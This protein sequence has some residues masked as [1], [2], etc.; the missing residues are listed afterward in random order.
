MADTSRL[1]KALWINIT[2]L[3]LLPKS[4]APVRF[5]LEK[6]PFDDEEE[7]QIAVDRDEYVVTGR[8]FPNADIYKEGAFR[9]EM[10]LTSKYPIEPPVVRFLT[11]VYHPNVAMDGKTIDSYRK[12]IYSF[13]LGT[14]CHHLLA[15]TARWK[16][17]TTLVDV[18][19]AIVKHIDEPDP[20]YAVNYGKVFHS[21]QLFSLFS[22]PFCRNRQGIYAEQRGIQ[23]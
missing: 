13:I 1:N 8:I 10:K 11:P 3:K 18:V 23:P 5:I 21:F 9:I 20:D 15:R 17:G 19:K 16:Q 22:F 4:D 7:E 14:F 2:R 6:S 12:E